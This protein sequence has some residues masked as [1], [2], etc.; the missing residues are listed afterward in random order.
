MAQWLQRSLLR[1]KVANL[2][3][4]LHRIFQQKPSVYSEK[5]RSSHRSENPPNMAVI[6]WYSI[7]W[8][9][10][11]LVVWWLVISDWSSTLVLLFIG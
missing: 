1:L 8:Y 6:F 7:P 10:V 11:L 3:M 9:R 5:N 2:N 4:F